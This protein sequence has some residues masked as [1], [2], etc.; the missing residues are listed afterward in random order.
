MK[1]YNDLTPVEKENINNR[2]VVPMD[3]SNV[4][5]NSDG[6][7]FTKDKVLIGLTLKKETLIAD[8][9]HTYGVSK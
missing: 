6:V 2:F 3:T 7:A 8:G 9:F 1:K 4:V 5:V